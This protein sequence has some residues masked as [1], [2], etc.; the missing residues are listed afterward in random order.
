MNVLLTPPLSVVRQA[1]VLEPHQP[2]H[3]CSNKENVPPEPSPRVPYP[4]SPKSSPLSQLRAPRVVFSQVNRHHPYI[5]QP[6]KLPSSRMLQPPTK[7]ILKVPSAIFLPSADPI[8]PPREQTPEPERPLEDADFLGTPIKCLVASL[9]DVEGRV[10]S[11]SQHDLTE[12][13]VTL[14]NRLRAHFKGEV[15]GDVPALAVLRNNAEKLTE[16]FVRDLARPLQAPTL[17]SSDEESLTE[18]DTPQSDANSSAANSSDEPTPKRKGVSAQQVTFA[19]DA[20][21]LTQTAIRTIAAILSTR[22]LFSAFSDVSLSS[23]IQGF[24]DIP[25]ADKL[26]LPNARKTTMLAMWA[27]QNVRVPSPVLKPLADSF[28]TAMSRAISGRL[29]KEGKKGAGCEALNAVHT[30]CRLHPAIF[31]PRMHGLLYPILQ[32]C[33]SANSSAINMR[34]R[35]SAGL[36]GIAMGLLNWQRVTPDDPLLKETWDSLASAVGNYFDAPLQASPDPSTSETAKSKGKAK[37]RPPSAS[38]ALAEALRDAVANGALPEMPDVVSSPQWAMTIISCLVVFLRDTLFS[39]PNALSCVFECFKLSVSP[40]VKAQTKILARLAWPSVMWAATLLEDDE[41]ES[42][43]RQIIRL[44]GDPIV[45]S[46][47][48]ALRSPATSPLEGQWMKMAIKYLYELIKDNH[49]VAI[50]ML[51][52]LVDS[53]ALESK[54]FKWEGDRLICRQLLDA[55]IM[56]QDWKSLA[57]VVKDIIDHKVFSQPLDG[58][59]LGGVDVMR[60]ISV[61]DVRPLT[62]GQVQDCIS[63]LVAAWEEIVMRVSFYTNDTTPGRPPPVVLEIWEN[64]VQAC[65]DVHDPSV[66]I[67]RVQTIVEMV[68]NVLTGYAVPHD[69]YPRSLKN[70]SDGPIVALTFTR[71]LWDS[72]R[73]ALG[74]FVTIPDSQVSTSPEVAAHLQRIPYA[75]LD[76]LLDMSAFPMNTATEQMFEVWSDFVVDVLVNAASDCLKQVCGNLCWEDETSR[77]LWSALARR[78]VGQDE[79]EG[80]TFEEGIDVLGVPFSEASESPISICLDDWDVWEAL[81]D[82]VIQKALSEGQD[83]ATVLCKITDMLSN[84]SAIDIPTSLRTITAILQRIELPLPAS[85]YTY[86]SSA[87]SPA[88]ELDAA[89]LGQELRSILAIINGALSRISPADIE[90]LQEVDAAIA[91]LTQL[92]GLVRKIPSTL[93]AIVIESLQDGLCVWLKPGRGVFR[94]DYYA[95]MAAAEEP[96]TELEFDQILPVYMECLESLQQA[97]PCRDVLVNLQAFF[98]SVFEDAPSP[99]FGP[100]A[101]QRFWSDNYQSLDQETLVPYPELLKPILRG[102]MAQSDNM[103]VPGLAFE[104]Q[105]SAALDAQNHMIDVLEDSPRNLPVE[106]P[107]IEETSISDIEIPDSQPSPVDSDDEDEARFIESSLEAITP[108]TPADGKRLLALPATPAELLSQKRRRLGRDSTPHKRLRIAAESRGELAQGRSPSELAPLGNSVHAVPPAASTPV[109][110]SSAI[111]L[112]PATASDGPRTPPTVLS[113]LSEAARLSLPRRRLV[114]DAVE[115]P[116]AAALKLT[117]RRSI[118]PQKMTSRPR[119]VSTMQNLRVEDDVFSAGGDQSLSSSGSLFAGSAKKRKMLDDDVDRPGPSRPQSVTCSPREPGSD[120]TDFCI[121]EAQKRLAEEV[122]QPASDDAPGF[123]GMIMSSGLRRQ[124]MDVDTRIQDDSISP[125]RE[126]LDRRLSRTASVPPIFP[127]SRERAMTPKPQRTHSSSAVSLLRLQLEDVKSTDRLSVE[128]LHYL[129]AVLAEFQHEVNEVLEQKVTARDALLGVAEVPFASVAEKAVVSLLGRIRTG[130][131]RILTP[132]SIYSFPSEQLPADEH[133]P[134]AELR[135]LKDT[136][137]IRVM[138]MSDLGFAEAYMYGE[139]ECEDLVSF[140]KVRQLIAMDSIAQV[141]LY[142]RP[143]LNGLEKSFASWL[144]S[145]PQSLTSYRFVNSI[146]NSRSNISAHYDISNTMFQAFLSEDMTYSCAIFD[147]LDGDLK[148]PQHYPP[149]ASRI[150]SDRC[151]SPASEG[152][153]NGI[154]K[155]ASTTSVRDLLL[156]SPDTPP[157]TV[158]SHSGKRDDLY[159][160]QMRKLRHIIRNAQLRPG[161]RVLEIGSGWGSLAILAVRETGCEVDTITLSV[162]QQELARA[163]IS[164]AG[165]SNS[166]RVH[167]L[168]YRKLPAEWEGRFD[169]VIS[170]EMIENVGKEYLDRYWE[171]IDWALD[172]RT[173][174]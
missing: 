116:S 15:A 58:E 86:S 112:V 10:I 103:V 143:Y 18:S 77:T 12:A 164:E 146:S 16:V 34:A 20:F 63:E 110:Q 26:F 40:K 27:I 55:S 132:S 43:W 3:H 1:N 156:N 137:W 53:T 157:I 59:N 31:L 118:S 73:N 144:F 52:R 100:A 148:V 92:V 91:M 14:G 88:P 69:K 115:V 145:I 54:D 38:D 17:T 134:R 24:L 161:H 50:R 114:L 37:Q 99:S 150:L 44:K 29:G 168:D 138:T 108:P 89:V 129:K 95:T 96:H 153:S 120:D 45:L 46:I 106:K 84:A 61:A 30:M 139:V 128:E 174:F 162:H 41:D 83:A 105:S 121:M 65:A 125:S 158:A 76:N 94:E 48:A 66:N 9:K 32:L 133:E 79:W 171:V 154:S 160:G 23:I 152:A 98:I 87:S 25:L 136:F 173:E 126:H 49:S 56:N 127:V 155:P 167:L 169:R 4:P 71:L 13:Y 117:H 67:E 123:E 33:A 47:T 113:P 68:V 135:V 19:R 75:V 111:V 90:E 101:F 97:S 172:P 80:W 82:R 5:H 57:A 141:F 147:D 42:I 93:P 109:H 8:P 7:S 60:L 124:P 39:S 11:A 22:V 159:E 165:L 62:R 104:T 149:V 74:P 51:A 170:V 35:A 107:F 166:I 102:L 140:F 163:R 130:H 6:R 122:E 81:L 131:L 151:A 85:A 72:A 64:L 2:T 36:G 70:E 21:I 119:K 142:N 28:I 78:V